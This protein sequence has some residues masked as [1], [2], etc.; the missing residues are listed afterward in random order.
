MQ[1]CWV[2]ASFLHFEQGEGQAELGRFSVL[3]YN[4]STK[5]HL[6]SQFRLKGKTGCGSADAFR[7][8]MD[9][10]LCRCTGYEKIWVAVKK[11][12]AARAGKAVPHA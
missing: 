6:L 11:V 2:A 4:P 8:L 5:T 3:N 7:T 1:G 9:G 12:V 10:N